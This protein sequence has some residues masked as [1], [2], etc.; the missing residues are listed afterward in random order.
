MNKL[1]L[2][3]LA[4]LPL[5]TLHA[6]ETAITQQEARTLYKT[7]TKKRVSVHDPSVVYDPNSGLPLPGCPKAVKWWIFHPSTP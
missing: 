1:T 7:T 4:L 6:Q 2:L 5:P 3:L